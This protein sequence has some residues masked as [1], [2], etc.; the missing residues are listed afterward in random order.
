MQW[1][2]KSLFPG[3]EGWV[4]DL[5]HVFPSWF[6][7]PSIWV[8]AVLEA[9][10]LLGLAVLGGCA[11]ILG[12]RLTNAIFRESTPQEVEKNVRY[13]MYGGVIAVITTGVLMGMTNAE[14]LYDSP[15]F[16]LKMIS[17]I[18]GIVLTF[19]CITFV[20]RQN[21]AELQ[22]VKYWAATV[23]NVW[24]LFCLGVL[25]AGHPH[26]ALGMVLLGGVAAAIPQGPA[27]MSV[28][29]TV[30]IGLVAIAAMNFIPQF[31][32]YDKLAEDG[33]T[34]LSTY[35]KWEFLSEE[36]K[37]GLAGFL[38]IIGS[39]TLRVM[40]M[41]RIFA[42]STING[43][44]S[45]TFAFSMAMTVFAVYVFAVTQGT[46]PGVFHVISAGLVLAVGIA[47]MRTRITTLAVVAAIV[48][49]VAIVT[50]GFFNF[51]DVEKGEA[52][53][54]AFMAINKGGLV[55]IAAI[56]AG[57]LGWQ[58]LGPQKKGVSVLG[59]LVGMGTFLT[60]ITVAAGGR[61]IGLS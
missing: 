31:N 19:G 47:S 1:N 10:H 13:W 50:Y 61:W 39:E 56:A 60:W 20:A 49:G 30:G 59:A 18:A 42:A 40:T 35:S 32:F 44:A 52:N 28:A 5:A 51:N 14:K 24:F 12:L 21:E 3:L 38:A 53:L 33:E 15:A 36:T 55:V 37:A 41:R 54:G 9:F 27:R 26:E 48:V 7:K 4:A 23:A 29:W 25:V 6:T 2:F 16:F 17:M 11:L 43:A 22:P 45:H 57:L 34:V 46:N 8:F 58:L